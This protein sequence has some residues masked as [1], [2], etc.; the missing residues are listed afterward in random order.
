MRKTCLVFWREKSRNWRQEKNRPS[1][2]SNPAKNSIPK[3]DSKSCL[4]TKKT[5]WLWSSNI[6]IR[7]MSAF[8]LA[9]PRPRRG[10]YLVRPSCRLKAVSL[11]CLKNPNRPRFWPLWA[12]LTP[13]WAARPCWSW[14]CGVIRGPTSSGPR[15]GNPS[16]RA[17]GSSSWT[18]IRRPSHSSSARWH[19][20][21]HFLLTTSLSIWAG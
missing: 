16:P 9:W 11:S 3:T 5:P 8:T 4:R 18:R 19:D 13:R 15:M 1:P 10:K 17:T 2:G 6:S 20:L 7:R 12:T 21:P 14:K